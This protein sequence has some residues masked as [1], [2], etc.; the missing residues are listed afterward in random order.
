MSYLSQ[1]LVNMKC[2]IQSEINNGD[3]GIL[4]SFRYRT[5]DGDRTCITDGTVSDQWGFF[6]KEGN[7]VTYS[8]QKATSIP[9]N[10][11]FIDK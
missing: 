1:L 8:L 5:G 2:K 4:K 9:F 11:T 6:V 7:Y 3:D 10:W